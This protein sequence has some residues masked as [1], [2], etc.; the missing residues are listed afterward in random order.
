MKR[1]GLTTARVA[2]ESSAARELRVLRA[3]LAEAEEVLSA[4]RNGEVDGVVVNGQSGPQVYTLSGTD[5]IYRQLIEAMSEAA[6]TLSSG[7]FILYS[8]MRLAQLL[9]RPLDQVLGSS[10][11][12]HVLAEDGATFDAILAGARTEPNRADIGLRS[13][14]G[15]VIPVR[16]SASCMPS[17]SGEVVFCLV[18]TDLSEQRR[19][20]EVVEAE[21]L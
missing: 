10:L 11:R 12:E 4:I 3:R 18:L 9:D 5:R 6:V 13:A 14:E 16:M 8:N 17:D 20:L 21:Q 15:R 2:P 19:L 1:A 7:G